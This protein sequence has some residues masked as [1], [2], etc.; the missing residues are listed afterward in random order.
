MIIKSAEIYKTAVNPAGYPD[1]SLPEFAFIGR[2]NVGKSSLI[3]KLANRKALA[4][5]SGTP[6]KTRA[7]NFFL[8]NDAVFFVD[9]PGYGYAKV[10]KGEREKWGQ[11][12]EGYLKGREQ[13]MAAVLLIDIRHEPSE[14]DAMMLNWL[15]YYGIKT[16]ICA[17]KS[18]KIKR[19]KLKAHLNVIRKN[20]ELLEDDEI[21]PFS[22]DNEEG[23][24][25][26]WNILRACLVSP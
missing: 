17:T 19:S 14:N 1:I 2:S 12:I 20:L 24:A 8:I 5:T 26:L 6:G 25:I 4:R 18:D 16:I 10:S 3:N 15:N 22:K 23:R 21:I 9:L 11:M 7:I 13:L